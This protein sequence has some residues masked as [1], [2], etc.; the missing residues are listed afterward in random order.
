MW[1]FRPKISC[2]TTTAPRG[3]PVGAASQALNSRPSRAISRV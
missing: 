1:L 3:A 2:S